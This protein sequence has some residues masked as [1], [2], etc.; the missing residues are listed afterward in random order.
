M[1]YLLHVIYT[2]S[3]GLSWVR[4]T[5]ISESGIVGAGACSVCRYATN[6]ELMYM[7]FTFVAMINCL[8]RLQ[9]PVMLWEGSN[10]P[11]HSG[12]AGYWSWQCSHSFS[13]CRDNIYAYTR[14][15][16][17]LSFIRSGCSRSAFVQLRDDNPVMF[18]EHKA[19]YPIS[20]KCQ[21]ILN[22][23]FLS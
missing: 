11:S 23:S 16:S 2:R 8:T 13:E 1:A 14:P 3:L 22:L 6:C 17:S 10:S 7:D 15:E 21:T 18:F 4:N 20:L 9:R 5:P 19:L 12:T